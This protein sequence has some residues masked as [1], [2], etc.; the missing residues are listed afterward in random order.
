MK[1][2]LLGLQRLSFPVGPDETRWIHGVDGAHAIHKSLFET[3]VEFALCQTYDGLFGSG[4]GSNGDSVAD[5]LVL[6]SDFVKRKKNYER[7]YRLDQWQSVLER[8]ADVAHPSRA[9][10]AFFAKGVSGVKADLADQAKRLGGR[11]AKFAELSHWFPE[12]RD[13]GVFFVKAGQ[14]PA[15]RPRNAGSMEWRCKAVLA[16]HY[17]DT[18]L[19]EWWEHCYDQY[20]DLLNL[21]AHPALGY[22]DN[23][24]P[25]A[26]RLLDLARMQVGIRMTFHRAILPALRTH[27]AGHWGAL[28][29][30]AGELAEADRRITP[31][32]LQYL[33]AVDQT[34]Y[35]ELEA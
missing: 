19:R 34:D 4:P 25:E 31:Q 11:A 30:I 21:F 17:P 14:D 5:R 9:T 23:F 27:F 3:Y 26:E 28:D 32:V 16:L 8:V 29:R 6:Y 15:V 33:L 18:R 24:R 10:E 22:D 13:E 2:Y 35:R 12:R 20:Y 7:L 1:R